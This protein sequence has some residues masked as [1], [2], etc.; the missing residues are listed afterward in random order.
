MIRLIRADSGG[1]MWVHESR[2]DEYLAAGHKPAAPPRPYS[3]KSGAAPQAEPLEN[4][5]ETSSSE[6]DGPSRP[7][8]GGT[9]AAV[10]RGTGENISTGAAKRKKTTKAK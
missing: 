6:R 10:G 7:E 1:E 5:G 3:P 2:L 4:S 8:N 9:N